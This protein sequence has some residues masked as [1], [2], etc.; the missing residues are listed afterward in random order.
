[1]HKD[2][3]GWRQQQ[4]SNL[5][6]FPDVDISS[7]VPTSPPPQ[8][9]QV[10]TEPKVMKL[11]E[12]LPEKL[13]YVPG[14]VD[15]VT[16]FSMRGSAQPNLPIA[17][18]GALACQSVLVSRKVKAISRTRPSLYLLALASTGTGKDYPRSV[19]QY[20]LTRCGLEAHIKDKVASGEGLEDEIITKQVLLLQID[21]VNFTIA[22]MAKG[23]QRFNSLEEGLL[24]LYSLAKSQLTGRIK[25]NNTRNY[26]PPQ[27]VYEPALVL[28]GTATPERFCRALTIDQIEGGLPGR[29]IVIE[30]VNRGYTMHEIELTEMPDD[31]L[32]IAQHWANFQPINPETGK[33]GNLNGLQGPPFLHHVGASPEAEDKLISFRKHCDE[34]AIR[35][36]KNNRIAAAL[37]TRVYESALRLSLVYA[38]SKNHDNPIIDLDAATWASEFMLRSNEGKIML[39]ERNVADN[40]FHAI[41]LR[42]VNII[43]KNGG[44]IT[45][46]RL[47]KNANLSSK[48]VKEAIDTLIEAERIKIEFAETSGRPR[49]EYVLLED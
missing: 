8:N 28:F 47:I 20:I 40:P 5:P 30:G 22:N 27:T 34:E 18:L 25:A 19:N 6:K 31:I 24:T 7:L 37:W 11:P 13:L 42:V 1:N 16:Q 17:T 23:E 10:I 14:F 12:P 41:C 45:H 48:T 39:V 46:S 32:E 33:P 43:Y 36:S 26:V 44:R 2:L 9:V 15:K 29:C 4:Q 21:E 38:C 35:L 49:L 3:R